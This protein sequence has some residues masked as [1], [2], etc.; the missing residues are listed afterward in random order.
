MGFRC[1]SF[2]LCVPL[3]RLWPEYF[4]EVILKIFTLPKLSMW[5][6]QTA[7]QQLTDSVELVRPPS[8]M[9]VGLDA[10]FSFMVLRMCPLWLS[11]SLIPDFGVRP[12]MLEKR[13]K[14]D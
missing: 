6:A 7:T 11:D 1:L 12:K 14:A 3:L 2:G 8:K 13:P 10:K 5:R 4:N 9:L